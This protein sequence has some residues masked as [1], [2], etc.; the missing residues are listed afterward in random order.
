MDVITGQEEKKTQSSQRSLFIP[1]T[2]SES[3][4][5]S[6]D[7]EA[8]ISFIETK[9]SPSLES[10]LRYILDTTKKSTPIDGLLKFAR[11]PSRIL[12]EV[13]VDYY[14]TYHQNKEAESKPTKKQKNTKKYIGDEIVQ[15]FRFAEIGFN[16]NLLFYITDFEVGGTRHSRDFLQKEGFIPVERFIGETHPKWIIIGASPTATVND[17]ENDVYGEKYIIIPGKINFRF[18]DRQ[19]MHQ[20]RSRLVTSTSFLKRH[21]KI[22]RM[23]RENNV[24][25]VI[26][27]ADKILV[28]ER[29]DTSWANLIGSFAKAFVRHRDIRF[30]LAGSFLFSFG[31][32]LQQGAIISPI[33]G[34]MDTLGV[35][36]LLMWIMQYIF[37]N[38][39]YTSSVVISAVR[40]DKIKAAEKDSVVENV[41][42]NLELKK[43]IRNAALFSV[44]SSFLLLAIY[45][46]FFMSYFINLPFTPFLM[47][48]IYITSSFFRDWPINFEQD[49]L[50]RIL[51]R[52]LSEDSGLYANILKINAVASSG[53]IV[54]NFLG[55]VAGWITM[56]FS[57]PAGIALS[58]LGAF[59]A[60]AKLLYP[61]YGSD[62]LVA[63]S[64]NVVPFYVS[65]HEVVVIPNKVYLR[66]QNR[67]TMKER[68]NMHALYDETGFELTITDPAFEPR[69]RQI[70]HSI[71]SSH[72]RTWYFNWKKNDE[73][74][75]MTI[76]LKARNKTVLLQRDHINGTI[77][78]RLTGI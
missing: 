70:T 55:I 72:S 65:D 20:Y 18:Y 67:I 76:R 21:S 1:R 34:M 23:A 6:K 78:Y 77:V 40:F 12:G 44:L 37:P 15:V 49:T 27:A 36:V 46:G 2:I 51:K 14:L 13:R 28:L 68:K 56:S 64:M 41:T 61:Y 50:F 33:L 71:A 32:G 5:I 43:V 17:G 16:R 4:K 63:L 58:V 25:P 29:I 59:A 53:D 26:L 74:A 9:E 45:P 19:G 57:V 24:E 8:N 30:T 54:F 42:I 22:R 35:L 47:G 31:T 3:I 10:D 52:S 75:K 62:Y 73:K 11:R 39:V 66:S 38:L 60:F 69:I 7:N 48:L